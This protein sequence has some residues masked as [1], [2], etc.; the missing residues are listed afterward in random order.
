MPHLAMLELVYRHVEPNSQ[1]H[2]EL[3][4]KMRA[5]DSD[6]EGDRLGAI[7]PELW[8]PQNHSYFMRDYL[9]YLS[10]LMEDT[11]TLRVRDRTPEYA[12][13]YGKESLEAR[14]RRYPL[15]GFVDSGISIV[16]DNLLDSLKCTLS[17]E[18]ARALLQDISCYVSPPQAQNQE[19]FEPA[20]EEETRSTAQRSVPSGHHAFH[21]PVLLVNHQIHEC[22]LDDSTQNRQRLNCV[23][24]VQ[25]LAILGIKDFPV[26]GLA[27]SGQYG[28]VSSTWFSSADNV[29]HLFYA[30]S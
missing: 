23:S 22:G 5:T 8:R 18:D 24:A 25:F 21:I 14:M 26:Y 1:E 30:R 13:Q 17:P 3:S 28:Y 19:A 29:R 6:E 10:E 11:T 2:A 15:A 7:A 27:T 9:E 12:A 16:I 20:H 4:K